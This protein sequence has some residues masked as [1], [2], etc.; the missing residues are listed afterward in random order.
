MDDPLTLDPSRTAVLVIDLQNDN[1]AP[2]GASDGSEG[3][4]HA[5]SQQVVAHAG[6]IADAARSAGGKVVHCHFVIDPEAGGAGRNTP[7]F[8]KI[9]DG[10]MVVRASWGAAPVAG[11]EPRPGD[12]VIARSRMSAFGGTQ[13]DI[14]L[15]NL[16]ID[17]VVVTGVHLCHAVNHTTRD[18]ADLGYRVLLVSDATASQSAEWQAA[19]LATGLTDIA[20]ILTT[21]A[22]ITGFLTK[23]S[24]ATA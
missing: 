17:T 15:R 11:A 23:Q 4:R 20:E 10:P 22:V 1:L 19:D 7:L 13:L 5:R 6:R 18:A 2:G 8:R 3:F 21:E 16:R 12:L 9:T 24:E 14:M